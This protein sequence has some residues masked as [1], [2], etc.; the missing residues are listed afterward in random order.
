MDT[1]TDE[2]RRLERKRSEL[3]DELRRLESAAVCNWAR[4]E[5]VAKKYAA[6]QVQLRVAYA[7]RN[8]PLQ[9]GVR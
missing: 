4:H 8:M 2:I 5:H 1:R 6:V 7:A 9:D 3:E